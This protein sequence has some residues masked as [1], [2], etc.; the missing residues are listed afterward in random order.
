MLSGGFSGTLSVA[1]EFQHGAETTTRKISTTTAS[2]TTRLL[3][4]S[5]VVSSMELIFTSAINKNNSAVAMSTPDIFQKTLN[6]IT[7]IGSFFS[8]FDI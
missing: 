8:I 3:R 5:Y 7:K 2:S 1:G 4:P 6:V